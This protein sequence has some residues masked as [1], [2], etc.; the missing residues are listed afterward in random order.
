MIDQSYHNTSIAGKSAGRQTESRLR[1]L[2]H[3]LIE[4]LKELNC[5]FGISRLVEKENIS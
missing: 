2:T 1:E 5:L 4:R 3:D